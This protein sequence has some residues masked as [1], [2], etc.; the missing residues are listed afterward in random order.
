VTGHNQFGRRE[1]LGQG[2]G[3]HSPGEYHENDFRSLIFNEYRMLQEKIDKIGSFRFTIKGWSVTAV[4]AGTITTSGKGLAIAAAITAGLLVMLFSF[5]LLEYD[6]VKHSRVYGQRAVRLEDIFRRITHGKGE[7]LFRSVPV[8]F[9]AHD[10]VLA[11]LRKN[12]PGRPKKPAIS[13]KKGP[14]I[15]QSLGPLHLLF[16]IVLM[17]LSLSPLAGQHG[18]IAKKFERMYSRFNSAEKSTTPTPPCS[19]RLHPDGK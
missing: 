16:Y 19:R 5:L 10:L 1:R 7:E 17:V 8:P 11:T 12:S 3:D 6:Q 4:I 14:G 9:T 2:L 18:A 15:W 13:V